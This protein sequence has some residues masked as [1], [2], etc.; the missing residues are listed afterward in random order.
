MEDLIYYTRLFDL[1][2]NVLTD[3][4]RETFEDYFFENLTIEEIALNNGV[5]KN[6]I[7]K[8]IKNIKGLLLKMEED[9]KFA[10]YISSIKNEFKNE[11]DILRR[12]EKY[13]TI[14]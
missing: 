5:S 13:D 2:K 14:I 11:E 10:G 6:A 12:L 3:K 1:Y 7:S 8:M 9:V 4:Q